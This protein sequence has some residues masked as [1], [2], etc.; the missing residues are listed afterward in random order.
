MLAIQKSLHHM[1]AIEEHCIEVLG[2][3]LYSR[4]VFLHN[5]ICS[6][7]VS[8]RIFI[9]HTILGSSPWLHEHVDSAHCIMAAF[10]A[11]IGR[12]ASAPRKF[13]GARAEVPRRP[14][15]GSAAPARRFRGAQARRFRGTRAEIPRHPKCGKSASFRAELIPLDIQCV[16]KLSFPC[17]VL[18]D[19][20]ELVRS[21]KRK[22]HKFQKS[23]HHMLAIQKSLHHMLAIEEH[24]IE[25]LGKCLYIRFVFLHNIICSKSVSMRIFISHTILGSSPGYTNMLTLPTASWLPLLPASAHFTLDYPELSQSALPG[26][27]TSSM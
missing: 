3:C 23:L 24:C 15:G 19:S 4:F 22:N 20:I 5:I 14:R 17:H 27:S 6:K 2:K 25:V 18:Y 8:M 16:K 9:S 21:S 12:S 11:C 7:S 1:L 26:S 13:R 10:V